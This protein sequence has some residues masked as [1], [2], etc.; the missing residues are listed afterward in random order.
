MSKLIKIN[1]MLRIIILL[2]INYS[3]FISEASAQWSL[4]SNNEDGKYSLVT[5]TSGYYGISAGNVQGES[6]FALTAAD[7]TN[8]KL[9]SNSDNGLYSLI[10]N[11][12][13]F[14]GVDAGKIRVKAVYLLN[15]GSTLD[16]TRL[17]FIDK[18]NSFIGRKQIFDTV[19][20]TVKYLLNGAD[21]NTAGTLTNVAYQNQSNSFIGRKQTFDTVNATVKYLLN[22]ADINTNGTL[23]NLAYQNG[24]PVFTDLVSFSDSVA[25]PVGYFVPKN[26]AGIRYN[27]SLTLTDT[28]YSAYLSTGNYL[29]ANGRQSN[30][31]L[32]NS[33]AMNFSLRLQVN[34]SADGTMN[35]SNWAGTGWTK[36]ELGTGANATGFIRGVTDTDITGVYLHSANGSL[37]Y[38]TISDAGTVSV[39][40]T[41]P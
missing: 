13:T 7:T 9:V 36:L 40:S 4:K 22:G 37:W 17:A 18:S 8:W 34:S 20:A 3:L 14:M 38:L 28:L 39:S 25:M 30:L 31:T 10:E 27:K 16:T 21:I 5:N 32:D 41:A 26:T 33:G 29:A 1:T 19:N 12:T 2:I 6:I 23:T 15:P 24:R 11:K 35:I